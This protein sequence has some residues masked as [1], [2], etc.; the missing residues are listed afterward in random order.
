MLPNKIGADHLETVAQSSIVGST[1]IG[2]DHLPLATQE[3]NVNPVDAQIDPRTAD[4]H[5]LCV[6]PAVAV[7]VAATRAYKQ[8]QS[9]DGRLVN[10]IKALK[11]TMAKAYPELVP[12]I[13]APL[14]AARE[15]IRK[16]RR[17]TEKEIV[18]A[19]KSLPA[20]AWI[21]GVRGVGA[22]GFG[23]IIG[24]TGDLSNYDNPA[25]VW[26]RL[27]LA[28]MP[29]GKAQR[30]SKSK[31]VALEAGFS[32]RRRALMWNLSSSLLK[33]NKGEY[34]RLY[35]ER[36]AYELARGITKSH[37]HKRALRY[38]IKRFALHLWQRWHRSTATRL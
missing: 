36:K 8:F 33:L 37:A 5:V 6:D 13:V 29:D 9:A 18:E 1:D 7:L 3:V 10:Q 15:P 16:E 22:L 23:Q 32:P 35:D 31:K 11:R 14:E 24:E 4:T 12:V 27:G 20:W 17:R 19:A 21:D 38:M 30:R 34:R 26:K 25:K 28:V 2:V